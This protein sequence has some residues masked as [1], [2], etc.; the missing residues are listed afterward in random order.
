[1]ANWK[2]RKRLVTGVLGAV[3]LLVGAKGS[4]AQ[5]KLG[6]QA[7]V[8]YTNRFEGYGGISFDNFQAGQNLPTRMN[9]AGI[10]LLGTMW[11]TQRWGVSAD[12]RFDGGT[13]PVLANPYK[14]NRPLVYRETGMLGGQMRGWKNQYAAANLH[15]F[16]GV[17][18]GT[19]DQGTSVPP[20]VVGLYTNR[21]KPMGVVGASLDFNRSARLAIR[22]SPDLVFE[23]FGTETRE[24][25]SISGGVVYRF[26]QKTH[27]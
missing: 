15:A 7:P 21:T 25:F 9:L 2:M 22:I 23:H 19:F 11:L 12:F 3:T 27:Y 5:S 16:G 24:F 18:H 14:V 13:T 17:S 20:Q 6:P 1:M 26:G 4:E 10:D 8:T